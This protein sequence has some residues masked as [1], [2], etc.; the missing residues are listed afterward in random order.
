[1]TVKQLLIEVTFCHKSTAEGGR[2]SPIF[3]G[4]RPDW[5]IGRFLENGQ[6][7]LFIGQLELA[8]SVPVAPGECGTGT[9]WV[10]SPE[11]WRHLVIG[12]HI[13]FGEGPR[14]MATATVT[15]ITEHDT[16]D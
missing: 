1:V 2:A 7:W 13:A 6:P 16:P 11:Y 3:S 12:D 5:H 9:V 4:Y 10:R 14:I 15:G 8:G